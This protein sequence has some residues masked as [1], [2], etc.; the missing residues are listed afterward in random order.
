MI[1]A[2]DIGLKN[3]LFT[4]LDYRPDD[5]TR[6]VCVFS[7]SDLGYR[8]GTSLCK[9]YVVGC[10]RMLFYRFLGFAPYSKFT[11]QERF[12]L[13]AG[14]ALHGIVQRNLKLI[15]GDNYK[16]EQLVDGTTSKIAGELHISSTTDAIYNPGP[17]W[18][19]QEIKSISASGFAGLI[20]P[21]PEHLTQIQTYMGC[22][23]LEWGTLMYVGF[24]A[25]LP[26]K[27][28]VIHFDEDHFAAI[29]KKIQ[30]VVEAAS[31][32]QLIS[33]PREGGNY[34]CNRCKY[35]E[36]CVEDGGAVGIGRLCA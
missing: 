36:L 32:P 26:V 30:V 1:V 5:A 22:L 28:F 13:D 31:G 10:G 17:C 9:K 34:I 2:P 6:L 24:E 19:V 18:C 15:M 27:E 8:S 12:R 20:N 4:A 25:G 3:A 16:P 11:P 7:A 29:V 14:T 33:P 23:G 35:A 21:K